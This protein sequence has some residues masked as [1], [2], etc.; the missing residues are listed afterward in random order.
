MLRSQSRIIFITMSQSL[1]KMM[2][3]RKAEKKVKIVYKY[4]D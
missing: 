3:L 2:R 4:R 1:S